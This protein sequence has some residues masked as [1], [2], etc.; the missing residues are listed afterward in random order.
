[1]CV[2]RL[3]EAESRL[4]QCQESLQRALEELEEMRY[5]AVGRGVVGR[6]G[7]VFSL[8][9]HHTCTSICW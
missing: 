8:K 6:R 1:M 3:E 7:H 5:L 9:L 2:C 4:T